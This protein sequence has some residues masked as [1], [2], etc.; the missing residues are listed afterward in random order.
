MRHP[1]RQL[2]YG[3][4]AEPTVAFDTVGRGV[5]NSSAEESPESTTRRGHPM[6]L[7]AQLPRLLAGLALYDRFISRLQ[8]NRHRVSTVW[9]C[10]GPRAGMP[11][12]P[13]GP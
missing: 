2:P 5:H 7:R 12:L 9:K 11:E 6:P 1:V 8:P 4:R 10:A 3:G 13:H